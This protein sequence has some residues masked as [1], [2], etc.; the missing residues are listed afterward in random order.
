[1]QHILNF[2]KTLYRALGKFS[3][4][5]IDL[6]GSF[7]HETDSNELFVSVV[8]LFV[9]LFRSLWGSGLLYGV[10]AISIKYELFK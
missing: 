4:N 8:N 7:I 9:N 10:A 3:G 1:M 5:V 6:L 2:K